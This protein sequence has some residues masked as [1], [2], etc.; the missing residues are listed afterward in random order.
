MSQDYLGFSLPSNG[1]CLESWAEACGRGNATSPCCTRCMSLGADF[2]ENGACGT[3]AQ[4]LLP[5]LF[6]TGMY[7]LV[8]AEGTR[9]GGLAFFCAFRETNQEES[10]SRENQKDDPTHQATSQ[11]SAGLPTQHQSRSRC[12]VPDA[13]QSR[14]TDKDVVPSDE[15]IT[16][17]QVGTAD[18]GAGILDIRW[19][20]KARTPLTTTT[21]EQADQ[22]I[23][24]RTWLPSFASDGASRR[25]SDEALPTTPQFSDS[26]SSVLAAIG[27]DRALHI[28]QVFLHGSSA[29]TTNPNDAFLRN[30]SNERISPTLEE[31]VLQNPGDVLNQHSR[32]P[33]QKSGLTLPECRCARLARI[34]LPEADASATLASGAVIGVGMDSLAD[35]GRKAHDAETW[36]VSFDPHE[37]GKILATG[38]DDCAIRLWDLRC[39]ESTTI[40]INHSEDVTSALAMENRRSHTMGVTSVTFSPDD[41]NWLLTG[42][43]DETVRIFDRRQLRYPLNSF[44]V[45]G[46][47]WRLKWHTA[48]MLADRLLLV[49]AC[50]GGSELWRIGD[51]QSDIERLGVFSGHQSMT[52]GISALSIRT[53]QRQS[54]RRWPVANCLPGRAVRPFVSSHA[55]QQLSGS[56]FL[57]CSFYD[58]LL[59][60]W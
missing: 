56:I 9:K 27:S 21:G 58:R 57:S 53:L 16:V 5:G 32:E 13:L 22:A 8:E 55:R 37:Q 60:I 6:A 3:N 30:S 44:R 10:E 17:H 28:L 59:A 33:C 52:Y 2:K 46:G 24:S 11:A 38:A 4:C 51:A 39:R 43:Y 14:S 1:D 40:E 36:C 25:G 54:V 29:P 19:L 31:A 35:D 12:S 48:E 41:P 45:S 18:V 23:R 49:A 20:T 15:C 34:V 50:H 42:S 7:A 26:C 47:V